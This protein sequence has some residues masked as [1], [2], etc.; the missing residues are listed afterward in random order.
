M[1]QQTSAR[2]ILKLLPILQNRN[3]RPVVIAVTDNFPPP[4][5]KVTNKKENEVNAG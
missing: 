3:K 1:K 2:V 4:Y 5:L